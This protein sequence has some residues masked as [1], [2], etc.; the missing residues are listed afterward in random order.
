MRA[1]AALALAWIALLAGVG[2]AA[3]RTWEIAPAGSNQATSNG[4]LTFSAS[5]A[6]VS[7]AVTL[8]GT[9]ASR[10]EG[11]VGAR[12]PRTNPRIGS[13]TSGRVSECSGG[14]VRLLF[15]ERSWQLYMEGFE[16]STA[17][18][19]AQNAQLLVTAAGGLVRCQY[20]AAI[21]TSYA[22][23]TGVMTISGLT[24]LR[25]T[26]LPIAIC[27]PGPAL[28]GTLTDIAESVAEP[29]VGPRFEKNPGALEYGGTVQVRRVT[30][31]NGTAQR[32]QIAHLIWANSEERNWTGVRLTCGTVEPS[33]RCEIDIAS[34]EESRNTTLEVQDEDR[35][36]LVEIE[37][38]K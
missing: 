22:E 32:V 10:A 11:T 33:A 25:Q 20:E 37:L 29:E 3:A 1:L 24:V 4:R 5:E 23:K 21:T 34:K 17:Y 6:S 35:H 36:Q 26:A 28:N 31:T 8:L 18:V 13:F 9:L 38:R 27:P 16:G 12:E 19:Y 15:P 7:C 30:L 14:E 2:V